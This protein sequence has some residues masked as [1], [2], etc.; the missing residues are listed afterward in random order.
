MFKFY[1][2]LS[3]FSELHVLRDFFS[4]VTR[5]KNGRK[6][7]YLKKSKYWSEVQ[8]NLI[9]KVFLKFTNDP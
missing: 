8:I 5:Y 4:T 2:K 6:L 1:E 7:Q 9:L 3:R